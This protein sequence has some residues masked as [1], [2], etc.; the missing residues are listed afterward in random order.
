MKLLIIFSANKEAQFVT[1]QMYWSRVRYWGGPCKASTEQGGFM[2]LFGKPVGESVRE[3][4]LTAKAV[5]EKLESV[6]PEVASVTVVEFVRCAVY[7]KK[8]WT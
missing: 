5:G 8:S 7:I 6:P 1:G 4:K 2:A 3:E